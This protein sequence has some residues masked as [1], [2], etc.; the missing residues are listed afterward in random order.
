METAG[1]HMKITMTKLT[2]IFNLQCLKTDG[3][4]LLE[5]DLE[6]VWGGGGL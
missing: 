3:L 6:G 4:Q 2:T 1:N 5:S